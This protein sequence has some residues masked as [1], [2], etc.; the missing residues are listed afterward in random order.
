MANLLRF[1]FND[2][3]GIFEVVENGDW[4]R[5]TD[6]DAL[7]A[8][9]AEA[10]AMIEAQQKDYASNN[11][12]FAEAEHRAKVAE[13]KLAEVEAERDHWET[14]AIAR[15]ARGIVIAQKLDA[16]EAALP[17]VYRLALGDAA[18]RFDEIA[19]HDLGGIEY[20]D[21]VR[22][23]IS[24]RE[25]LVK[26]VKDAEMDA[27]YIRALPTPTADELMARIRDAEE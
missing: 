15:Q 24:N 12:R 2:R 1:D 9:L 3:D 21:L 25:Q 14:V 8:K 13:A 17:A 19:Q 6:Y 18:E 20:S 4:V 10:D 26:S 11:V 7:A 23:P 27:K 22:I 16:A 5:A